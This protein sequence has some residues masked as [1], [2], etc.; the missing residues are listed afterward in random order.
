MN[1]V[2]LSWKIKM[3]A[4]QINKR[5]Y[6][7]N[8]F[9]NF[10]IMRKVI[11]MKTGLLNTIKFNSK[12]NRFSNTSEDEIV[13]LFYSALKSEEDF[14][15]IYEYAKT[16]TFKYRNLVKEFT[17][18]VLLKINDSDFGINLL[19][20]IDVNI[21]LKALDDLYKR[22]RMDTFKR[23]LLKIGKYNRELLDEIT[24]Y[25]ID[26]PNLDVIHGLISVY[27]DKE[28]IM[29]KEQEKENN[30]YE[31]YR[32]FKLIIQLKI[33]GERNSAMFILE[34]YINSL[35][36]TKIDTLEQ[37]ELENVLRAIFKREM[38]IIDTKRAS[39]ISSRFSFVL[40]DI[41]YRITEPFKTKIIAAIIK[42]IKRAGNPTAAITFLK[43]FPNMRHELEDVLEEKRNIL[44]LK[45]Y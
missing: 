25:F 41:K 45:N 10:I 34:S 12:I 11:N 17:M 6:L 8:N 31:D 26:S 19:S 16:K 43:T 35:E 44:K 39:D 24:L 42:E 27:F 14:N 32:L 21:V 15:K 29:H 2:I 20:N 23:L 4:Y 37:Y 40:E 9:I 13:L 1:T 22:N 38:I 36:I 18:A 30:Y 28:F 33:W 7:T 3:D 5:F